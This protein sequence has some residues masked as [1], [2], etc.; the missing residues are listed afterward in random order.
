MAGEL[1]K[2]RFMVPVQPRLLLYLRILENSTMF[3]CDIEI[4]Q[5]W[6]KEN[7]QTP[8]ILWQD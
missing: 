6:K 1:R 4:H 8:V 3:Y 2:G 7:L 5:R